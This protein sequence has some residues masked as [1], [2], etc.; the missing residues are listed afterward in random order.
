MLPPPS[1]YVPPTRSDPS[2]AALLHTLRGEYRQPAMAAALAR[3]AGVIAR[4]ASGSFLNEGP[5]NVGPAHRFHVGSITKSLTTLLVARCVEDGLLRYD[6]TV[7]DALPHVAV[8]P[9]YAPV[10][11]HDL[12]TNRAG[13]IPYQQHA[14]EHPAH[15]EVLERVIPSQTA[16]PWA[17]R[18]RVA[19]YAL[20]QAPVCVP[21]T[22]A[23]YSNVG[24]AVLG[25]VVETALQQAYEVAL[26]E[27]VL[28]PLGMRQARVGGW[29][30]SVAEPDQ[31]R[32]HYADR[33]GPRPQ[34]LDDGYVLPAW[35][36]P[37]G[38]VSCTIDDLSS[39]ALEVLRGLRGEGCLL[40]AAAHSVIHATQ[41]T[42]RASTLYQGAGTRTRVA[43]G[44]GW[45]LMNFRGVRLSIADGSAGTFYARVAVLPVFDVAFA[46]L[47]N[48]GDGVRALDAAACRATGLPWP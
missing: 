12:L 45:G 9:E 2:I 25:H 24:W 4:A 10:T 1:T 3:S 35:M 23:I 21:G 31:P 41:F 43:C 11:L 34:A 17:Q 39:Y 32:G 30:A 47:T 6:L 15:V 20:A 7:R 26:A 14:L 44:Y 16:D 18:K 13:L 22:K 37:A 40:P 46:G 38:G 28:L 33:G 29:P 36:N 8:R 48:A 42:E 5:Q 27:R 19:D